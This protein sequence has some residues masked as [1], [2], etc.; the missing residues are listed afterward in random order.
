MKH[1]YT[2]LIV[3]LTT[4]V[5][6]GQSSFTDYTWEKSPTLTTID[7]PY[8][9][10]SST[11]LED[12]RLIILDFDAAYD[13]ALIQY[14]V[15]HRK[16]RVNTEEGVERNNRVYIPTTNVLELVEAKARVIQPNGNV[17]ELKEEDI[18]SS[19]D[20][21]DEGEYTFFALEGLEPGSEVEQLIK[22]KK[23]PS[24]D[25][26]ELVYQT[27]RWLMH[28]SLE[29][30]SP[31]I[32]SI[33]FKSY[34]GADSVQQDTTITD[35]FVY[36][37][38]MD[39]I[40]PLLSEPFS[41]RD[42][43]LLAVMYKAE[44]N[45]NTGERNII[46]YNKVADRLFQGMH[47]ELS[48]KEEKAVSKLLEKRI[49]PAGSQEDIIRQIE[50]YLK[51]NFLIVDGA[52]DA[53]LDDIIDN[54]YA[55]EGD[56]IRLY[57]QLFTMADI[58][59]EFGL[60]CDRFDY[61]F[62]RE[63]EAYLFLRDWFFY[64]PS[65]DQFLTPTEENLRLGYL[66]PKSTDMYG[67]FIKKVAL[68]GFATGVSEVKYIP[69][70]PAAQNTNVIRCTVKAGNGFDRPEIAFFRSLSGYNASGIQHYYQL[71]DEKERT[72][73]DNVFTKIM[74]E[75][76][77]VLDYTVNNIQP[78]EALI[79]PLEYEGTLYYPNLVERAGPKV[80]LNIGMLI[81]AQSEMYSEEERQL[82][83][84]NT[85]NRRYDR[86]LTIQLPEGATIANLDALDI[87]IEDAEK[88]MGFM[89]DY[90]MEGSTL[91]IQIDEYY[92]QIRYPIERYEEFREVINAAADFN[93]IKLVVEM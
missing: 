61:E 76:V 83:I 6:L 40:P 63:F 33:A 44:H 36:R 42:K 31:E 17:V 13:N 69:P 9:S 22:F 34:N 91:T 30:Q 7:S 52:D 50:L 37:W 45:Y 90:T 12:H 75:E 4:L 68:S 18:R 1:T 66:M 62:D 3:L 82:P 54:R 26:N 71:M 72:E 32:L 60:T 46:S 24:L 64:F 92:K 16:I 20:L 55:N 77:E 56:M 27:N 8:T 85:F 89:V 73:L 53:S 5:A 78:E 23:P 15:M 79:K 51:S 2:T 21:D 81:G 74:G 87:A 43:H 10:K 49:S 11:V 80:L 28:G 19:E 14:Q 57:C 41:A 47:Q 65:I 25:G 70:V 67:L 38:S 29:V 58:P 35:Q 48:R 86:E 93:K 84:E 59:Y 39:T 88:T